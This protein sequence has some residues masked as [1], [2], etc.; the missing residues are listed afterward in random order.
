MTRCGG[1]L[2]P[3]DHNFY[4]TAI[5][6]CID[7]ERSALLESS[8]RLAFRSQ[9]LNIEPVRN[10][11]FFSSHAGS[12]FFLT[13]HRDF[14]EIYVNVG[15]AKRRAK[16]TTLAA[17]MLGYSSLTYLSFPPEHSSTGTAERWDWS[18]QNGLPS[19]VVF[20]FF[21]APGVNVSL[22]ANNTRY[23]ALPKL[24]R[25]LRVA[26]WDATFP[27]LGNFDSSSSSQISPQL[28]ARGARGHTSG[29]SDVSKREDRCA[30]LTAQVEAGRRA[31]IKK[32]QQ[33]VI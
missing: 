22:H 6:H 27:S 32:K 2:W 28:R 1:D 29:R 13:A 33:L 10:F 23:S 7:T 5:G 30:S 24:Q 21:D 4:A 19:W 14:C 15:R 12:R 18:P 9:G 8:G 25:S 26:R 16:Q 20:L 11:F 31:F 17:Y 3:I